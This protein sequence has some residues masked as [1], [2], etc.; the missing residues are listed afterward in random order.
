M[1]VCFMCEGCVAA[2]SFFFF[3][4]FLTAY[5]LPNTERAYIKNKKKYDGLLL[6]S[7]VRDNYIS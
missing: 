2:V 7:N 3:G 6:P 5:L 4:F 1:V